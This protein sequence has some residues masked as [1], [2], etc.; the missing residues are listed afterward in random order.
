L[1]KTVN[2]DD[3]EPARGDTKGETIVGLPG[4]WLSV[5]WR[6]PAWRQLVAAAARLGRSTNPYADGQAFALDQGARYWEWG[7]PDKAESVCASDYRVFVAGT[8]ISRAVM[9]GSGYRTQWVKGCVALFDNTA[10]TR[11][12]GP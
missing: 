9:S 12:T 8:S 5:R 7:T 2:R 1:R 3:Y 4:G 6:S 11:N 10:L